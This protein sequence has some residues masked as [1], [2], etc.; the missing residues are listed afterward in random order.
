MCLLTRLFRVWEI[1]HIKLWKKKAE[2]VYFFSKFAL[3]SQPPSSFTIREGYRV[4]IQL[5]LVSMLHANASIAGLSWR[6]RS[7]HW[8]HLELCHR[9]PDT[10]RRVRGIAKS[11]HVIQLNWCKMCTNASYETASTWESY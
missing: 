2:T 4:I 8:N 5:K 9:N 11:D 1:L 7:N 6:I 10:H 3:E